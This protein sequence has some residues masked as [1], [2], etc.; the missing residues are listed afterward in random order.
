VAGP[1]IESELDSVNG[2]S[3]NFRRLLLAGLRI[4]LA[5]DSAITWTVNPAGMGIYK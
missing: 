3:S 1:D 2:Q 4:I 5:L